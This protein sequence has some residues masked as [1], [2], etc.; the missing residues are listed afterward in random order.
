MRKKQLF[1]YIGLFVVSILAMLG[2]GYSILRS[3]R[4]GNM[5]DVDWYDVNG[6]EFV[7][8]TE[9]ELYE[10]AQLSDY[11]DFAGQTI[12][13]G[14]DI[15]VNEGNAADWKDNAP[16]KKWQPITEFAGTFDGQGHS[17]S[18]LYG[19]SAYISM[20]LFSETKEGCVIKN[21]KLLNSY[22]SNSANRGLGS[23]IGEGSGTIQQVYSDAYIY[24]YGEANGGIGGLITSKLTLEECW[25][26]GTVVGEKRSNG[27][28]IGWV[29]RQGNVTINNCLNSGQIE[30]YGTGG[31]KTGG[32]IGGVSEFTYRSDVSIVTIKDSLTSGEIITPL[33][34][35]YTGAAVGAVRG[36]GALT[37]ENTYAIVSTENEYSEITLGFCD[38]KLTG[39]AIP[40]FRETL[41]GVGGYQWTNLDF[42]NYWSCVENGTPILK[43]F[44]ENELSLAGVEKKIDTSWYQAGAKEFILEDAADLWGFAMLTAET[45]F[46]GVVIKLGADI[47]LNESDRET[48]KE[49][50]PEY[51]WFPCYSFSGIFNGQGHTIS[52]MYCYTNGRY[53]GM[54]K[55][56][57]ANA[58]VENF[59][60]LNSYFRGT[61]CVGSVAGHGGGN[62]SDIYTDAIVENTTEH[63]GGI[64]GAMNQNGTMNNCWFD[65]EV[66]GGTGYTGG[67]T[68]A[69]MRDDCV[70]IHCLN[71][72]VVHSGK[73]GSTGGLVGIVNNTVTI[74]DSLN[75]GIIDDSKSTLK[76]GSVIGHATNDSSVNIIS[77]Y[78]VKESYK[79]SIGQGW[80]KSGAVFTN[81]KAQLT[82]ASAYNRTIL[83]FNKYWAIN[84]NG[85]PILQTFA[86]E[87]PELPNANRPYQVDTDWFDEDETTFVITTAEQLYGLSELVG[88]YD[89]EGITI[90]LGK[91]I[92]LNTGSAASWEN[93]IPLNQWASINNFN[94]TFDGQGHTISGLYMSDGMWRVGLF[95][96]VKE[97][98]VIKNVKVT[99]SYIE[100][101][102]HIGGIAGY[103][104][105]ANV[106]GVYS[107]A[108]VKA[109]DGHAG[110]VVG[111]ISDGTVDNAWFA[112][113]MIGEGMYIGGIASFTVADTA[114]LSN[115]L[116]T[117]SVT[118]KGEV[119][120][121]LGRA[122]SQHTTIKYSLNS[123]NVTSEGKCGSVLG[124]I[125]ADTVCDIAEGVYATEESA[126]KTTGNGGTA[127]VVIVN[128]KAE[129]SGDGGYQRTILDFNKNWAVR[130]DNTPVLKKFGGT[131][132]TN[133]SANRVILPDTSWYNSKN[134]TYVLN[135]YADLYGFA[136]LAGDTNFAGKTVKLGADI[137]CNKG[138]AEE[139]LENPALNQ[140]VTIG[141]FAGTFDGQGKIIKGLCQ[142]NESA[143]NVGLFGKTLQGAVIKNVN[144][145][146]STFEGEYHIGSI[147][148]SAV[149]TTIQNVYSDA[150]I[151]ATEGHVGG[152]AGSMSGSMIRNSWFDGN[153]VG[154]KH[155]AGG[156]TS[157]M[158]GNSTNKIEH[159]LNTGSVAA[160]SC[161]GGIVGL[162]SGP[163]ELT[164]SLST[165]KIGGSVTLGSA[166]GSISKDT[167]VK[168]SAV[169]GARDGA[170]YVVASGNYSGEILSYWNNSLKGYNGYVLTKLDFE[171]HWVAL[172]NETPMLRNFSDTSGALN[173]SDVDRIDTRWYIE[174]KSWFVIST[175][176]QLLGLAYLVNTGTDFEGKTVRLGKDI[177]FNDGDAATYAENAPKYSWTPIGSTINHANETARFAGTFD[178]QLHTISGLYANTP[179][180]WFVGLFGAV[181]DATIKNVKITNSYFVGQYY[182]SAVVGHAIDST[183]NTVY[184]D[185][186][187][188]ATAG[189]SGGI[190]GGIS[191]VT[192]L[193]AWFDGKIEVDSIGGGIA[194][195]AFTG[196]EN[197][198]SNCLNTATIKGGGNTGGLLGLL[199]GTVRML[200]CLS[201][202]E[203][204]IAT[205]AGSVGSV[206]GSI[207]KDSG[208]AKV[209]RVY[210]LS[211]T[212]SVA[213]GGNPSLA[214]MAPKIYADL[215]GYNGYTLTKLD[216][217]NYW[218]AKAD[219][220]PEL[221]SFSDGSGVLSVDTAF[222]IST[223]WYT[224]AVTDENGY[225][226]GTKEN[227]YILIDKV[228]LYGFADLVNS[229]ITF[230]GQYV[231]LGDDI[232]V[233]HG[234]LE[235]WSG[236]PS[237]E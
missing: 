2:I 4:A 91:N 106:Q 78:T 163:A 116:N 97:G 216:F 134:N 191:N 28:M 35:A 220:T 175:R 37:F 79:T 39:N 144:I 81:T 180:A 151:K 159:C 178:G 213:I 188:Y 38:G 197:I 160:W 135:D 84:Q 47:T 74:K 186:M 76:V 223:E 181:E 43:C 201:A 55:Q 22:F 115:C 131:S 168:V 9:K 123:G 205:S 13:L 94:G 169:Y 136:V 150:N 83:D 152:I 31:S 53:I 208:K 211:S 218:V 226:P 63:T 46:D 121:I 51:N 122:A 12:K 50:E 227:P 89:F 235:D 90:K 92:V 157:F 117:G 65:G 215:S 75:A 125:V 33:G 67:I 182:V 137:T 34:A 132:P 111:T 72:G 118:G 185:A 99:N 101:G 68:S 108:I 85:T 11:Y 206:I 44:S 198:M 126:K 48:W 69:A 156:I 109:R 146:N 20:G 209:S 164:D 66:Y 232:V 128:T 14:A 153:A 167:S 10:F 143:W 195:V 1:I 204:A 7:I 139:W 199:Q 170:K 212:Y 112:G 217:A 147:V 102:Y 56:V 221:K 29:D 24:S 133:M 82:G 25:F 173:V 162:I 183:I 70:I 95:G 54:F 174:D 214:T 19:K 6:K 114:V 207:A 187:L 86:E 58:N 229:G 32:F 36:S 210:A 15:V 193:N 138:N 158:S 3:I 190:A 224:N 222:R 41:N 179:D 145:E 110:G 87:I 184:S 203:T 61:Y 166:I 42:D 148:G 192:I 124:Y 40:R 23:I 49:K 219:T 233:N 236:T 194:G 17:I 16:E 200:D 27:G 59:K 113:R 71:T 130:V 88:S 5:L 119:G 26:D 155:Y 96:D 73:T 196:T 202:S 104:T 231:S 177:V 161:A 98:A 107:E 225:A 62:I 21:F 103:L 64:L 30:F 165:G 176:E 140:W 129:L 237:Y 18:G 80:T 8:S 171:N 142:S 172:E 77:T 234:T 45:N 189:N 105:K 57:N 228:D 93:T 52:G 120:G 100:G 60:L 127:G 230:E 141:N 149:G 154:V